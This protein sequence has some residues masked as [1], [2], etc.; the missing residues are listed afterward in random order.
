MSVEVDGRA[1]RVLI[2]TGSTHGS[3]SE[4]GD[5]IADVLRSHGLRVD[6][7]DAAAIDHF[8]GYDAAVIGSAVYMGRWLPDVRRVIERNAETLFE[9]P[10]WLF[11]S[12]PIGDPPVPRGRS[13][14]V[15]AMQDLVSAPCRVF[16]GRLDKARLSRGERV[17]T[18]VVRAPVGDFRPVDEIEGW[19]TEIADD[20]LTR[21]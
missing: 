21:A 3:T 2:V 4:I 1:P 8:G 5:L 16:P 15:D 18:R 6:H 17:I 19:A 13:A 12:G 9:L 20:V 7:V 14:D 10:V 11:E